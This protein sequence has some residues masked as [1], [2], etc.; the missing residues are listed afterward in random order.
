ML[1]K[2]ALSI[3]VSGCVNACSQHH[4]F[5]IGIVGLLKAN[6]EAYQVF[7]GGSARAAKTAKPIARAA[8]ARKVIALVHRYCELVR[9]LSK[10]RFECA[11]A[12]CLRTN[13]ALRGWLRYQRK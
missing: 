13:V 6:A 8:P 11:Y 9:L 4:V 12:C 1:L 2:P 5:D 10:D 3:R 7:V